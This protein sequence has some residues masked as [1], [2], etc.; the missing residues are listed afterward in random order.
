M[1]SP[2]PVK[3]KCKCILNFYASAFLFLSLL[4][5]SNETSIGGGQSKLAM[6]LGLGPSRSF[7]SGLNVTGSRRGAA[8]ARLMY[9]V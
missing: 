7:K 2:E 6:K 1:C 4:E 9:K 5:D 3:N 8:R